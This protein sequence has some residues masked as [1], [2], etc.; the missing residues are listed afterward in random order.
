QCGVHELLAKV[1]ADVV[2]QH[3]DPARFGDH[4]VDELGDLRLVNGVH[5]GMP[6]TIHLLGGLAYVARVDGGALGDE[7]LDR[8]EADAARTTEDHRDLACQPTHLHFPLNASVR[9]MSTV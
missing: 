2:E 1:D 7:L 3:V 6:A 8:G 5:N 4:A 9:S